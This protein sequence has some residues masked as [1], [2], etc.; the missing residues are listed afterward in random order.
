MSSVGF[1]WKGSKLEVVSA[2]PELAITAFSSGYVSAPTVLPS[3]A[4]Q[5][6]FLK[7]PPVEL[8]LPGLRGLVGKVWVWVKLQPIRDTGMPRGLAT[9]NDSSNRV[10]RQYGQLQRRNFGVLL[11]QSDTVQIPMM[12]AGK[13]RVRAYLLGSSK[14]RRSRGVWLEF[15]EVD[16]RLIPGA[17]PQQVAVNVDPK[18]VQDGLAELLK[19]EAASGA[20]K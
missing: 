20:G 17:G 6:L 14:G 4:S 8:S 11:R 12:L 2:S 18:K 5:V 3:G 16:I 9:W 13:F 1:S 19:L 15:G 7:V 10:A